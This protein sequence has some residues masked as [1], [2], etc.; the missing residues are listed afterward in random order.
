MGTSQGINHFRMPNIKIRGQIER[1]R[2]IR[3][4]T[5]AR[6]RLEGIDN[7]KKYIGRDGLEIFE[8]YDKTEE[9]I[10]KPS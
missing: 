5:K 1:K 7:N 6:N 9:E 3:R 8:S 2:G 10:S 4:K